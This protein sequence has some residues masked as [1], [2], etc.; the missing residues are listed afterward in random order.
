[1]KRL[2][3]AKVRSFNFSQDRCFRQGVYGGLSGDLPKL[4]PHLNI[5]EPVSVCDI[6]GIKGL[7]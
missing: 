4:F 6:I 1:M 3:H 5:P 7:C 2:L